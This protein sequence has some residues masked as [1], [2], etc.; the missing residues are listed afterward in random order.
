MTPFSKV[1]EDRERDK[2]K[3]TSNNQTA[4]RIIGESTD[5]IPVSL[6]AT[7]GPVNPTIYNLSAPTANTE[8]SQSITDGT[9][10]LLI[11]VRGRAK[12][13]FAFTSTESGTNYITIPAGASYCASNLNASSL[14]LYIQTDQASQIIEILE[15]G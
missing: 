13:Q 3:E 14:T 7:A 9:Q 8:V 10:Q 6:S 11:R 15:W 12:A 4:V 1:R 2:F 5:P